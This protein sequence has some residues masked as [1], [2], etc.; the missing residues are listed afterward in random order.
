MTRSGTRL[1]SDRPTSVT[2]SKGLLRNG[3]GSIRVGNVPSLRPADSEW[4]LPPD[5]PEVAASCQ[6]RV[7][8][9]VRGTKQ[10]SNEVTAIPTF[11]LMFDRVWCERL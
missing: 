8:V 4:P 7:T 2:R 9:D 10:R 6:T 3:S 5:S 1:W 11:D